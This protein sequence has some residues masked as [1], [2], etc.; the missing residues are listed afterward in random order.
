MGQLRDVTGTELAIL[1]VLWEL[2]PA[3]VR[4]VSDR[5]YPQGPPSAP[6]TVL[7]LIGRLEAKGFVERAGRGGGNRFAAAVERGTLV[8]ARLR[9]V[10][11]DLCGGSMASL[12]T[13]LVRTESL[14]QDDRRALRALV[15]S[16]QPPG[17]G[18]SGKEG[19]QRKAKP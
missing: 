1:E 2:G 18:D 11:E 12:L 17:A 3:T 6:A 14:S 7:K 4:Q 15:E 13:H 16:W 10:A 8:S 5:L 19:R 9:G